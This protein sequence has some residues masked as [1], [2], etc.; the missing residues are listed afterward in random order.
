MQIETI[1]KAAYLLNAGCSVAVSCAAIYSVKAQR[2]L[3]K[4]IAEGTQQIASGNALMSD[5]I[6]KIQ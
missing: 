5:F 4:T 6:S 1:I 3:N 2:E